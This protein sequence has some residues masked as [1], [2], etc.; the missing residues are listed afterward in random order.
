MTDYQKKLFERF[1]PNKPVKFKYD[2][3]D[4]EHWGDVQ[5]AENEVN[6]YI[7]PIRGRVIDSYWDGE[8]CGDAWI[9]CEVPYTA[10]EKVLQDGFFRY[11]PWQS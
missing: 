2:V 3:V 10:L 1:D 6:E 8:D 4:C 11:T 9:M 5:S 7:N